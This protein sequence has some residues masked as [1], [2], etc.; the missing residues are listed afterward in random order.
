[1]S[2]EIA[3]N[4]RDVRARIESAAGRASR[5]AAE[6]SIVAV[7]KTRTPAE[8]EMAYACGIRLIGE[9]RVGEAEAK[10]AELDLPDAVWHMV[11]HVQSRKARRVV[12]CFDV[13]QSVDSVR[14]AHRL[15]ARAATAGLVLPVLIEVNVAGEASKYGFLPTDGEKFRAAVAGILSLPHLRVDGLMTVAPMVEDPEDVRHVFAELRVLRQALRDRFPQTEWS[16]LSMGMTDDFEVAVEEG[17]TMV[18][19]GRAIFGPRG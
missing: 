9:N 6:V 10:R 14:L 5:D 1:M 12:H 7:S 19:I 11:G 15:D 17:A 3:D 2:G 16:H 18:R 4:V 8:I 13:V